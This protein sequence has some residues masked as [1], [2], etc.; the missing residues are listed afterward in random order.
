LLPD[1][2]LL[3]LARAAHVPFL[4][5]PAPFLEALQAFLSSTAAAPVSA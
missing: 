2:R 1:G 3:E 4:S 5:H